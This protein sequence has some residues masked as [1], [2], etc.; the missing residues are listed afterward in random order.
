MITERNW[1]KF[2]DLDGK[3]LK[4]IS[5]FVD[6]N[7]PVQKS[8][9]LPKRDYKFLLKEGKRTALGRSFIKHGFKFYQLDVFS[10]GKEIAIG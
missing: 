8:I 9:T 10:G 5:D 6:R 3:I 1:Q 4:A 2:E 7:G